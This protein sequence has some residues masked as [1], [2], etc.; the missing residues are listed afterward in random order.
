MFAFLTCCLIFTS[1]TV[2]IAAYI[3]EKTNWCGKNT[4]YPLTQHCFSHF[5][6]RVFFFPLYLKLG[7]EPSRITS[8]FFFFAFSFFLFRAEGVAL[9]KWNPYPS[10]TLPFPS[11]PLSVCREAEG[12]EPVKGALGKWGLFFDV[13]VDTRLLSIGS[14]GKGGGKK[15]FT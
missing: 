5:C 4:V 7:V 15:L 2:I 14:S 10:F 8:V 3:T 6:L 13:R 11:R 1:I 12:V 9:E